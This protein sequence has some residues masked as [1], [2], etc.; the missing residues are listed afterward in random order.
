M[1]AHERRLLRRLDAG[2]EFDDQFARDPRRRR[3]DIARSDCGEQERRGEGQ[4][5]EK[6]SHHG[7][8]GRTRAGATTIH[9][10]FTIHR[11]NIA[12]GVVGPP[13]SWTW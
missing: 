10:A 13:T 5:R 9:G 11:R 1:A 2:P 7:L 8:P 12:A 4:E 6:S 3:L